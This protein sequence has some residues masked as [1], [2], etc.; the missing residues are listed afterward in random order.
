MSLKDA[1]S[2]FVPADPGG[3]A[4]DRGIL[5]E[6][7]HGMIVADFGRSS[8]RRNSAKTLPS[9]SGRGAGGEGF[10]GRSAFMAA[11]TVG[12]NALRFQP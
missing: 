12:G 7:I 6:G 3:F 9:P 5:L 1:I 4:G 2:Q 11:Q 8:H 10:L